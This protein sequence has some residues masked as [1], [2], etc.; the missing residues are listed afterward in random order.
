LSRQKAPAR[1]NRQDP[2]IFSSSAAKP[3]TRA[4]KG[5]YRN[6]MRVGGRRVS[7][8]VSSKTK[9]NFPVEIRYIEATK[10]TGGEE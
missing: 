6:V 10:E 7:A 5:K 9:Y 2:N 3:N 4:K 8:A 1:N